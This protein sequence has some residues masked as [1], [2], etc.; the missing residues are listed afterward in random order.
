MLQLSP[1]FDSFKISSLGSVKFT[2]LDSQIMKYSHTRDDGEVSFQVIES[3][4][5][6]L[7][8]TFS[9]DSKETARLQIW[10]AFKSKGSSGYIKITKC[11]RLAA[12]EGWESLSI[13]LCRIYK[14]GEKSGRRAA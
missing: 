3:A 8:S 1:I 9:E 2:T 13:G 14:T 4:V 12:S 11:R 6:K 5:L 7:A 10:A